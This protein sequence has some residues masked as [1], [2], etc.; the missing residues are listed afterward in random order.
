MSDKKDTVAAYCALTAALSWWGLMPLY[1]CFLKSVNPVEILAHRILWSFSFLLVVLK[2]ARGKAAINFPSFEIHKSFIPGLLLSVNWMAF[3][4][5]SIS[6]KALQASLGYFLAPLL[7]AALGTVF[8]HERLDKLKIL[9]LTL[10]LIGTTV[11]CAVQEDFPIYGLLLA[12]SFSSLALLRKVWP[13]HDAI[14]TTW[15]ETVV[16]LPVAILAFIFVGHSEQLS[17]LGKASLSID[18][19]LLLAGPLTVIPLALYAF[20][21]PKIELSDSAILQYLTPTVTFLLAILYFHE[22]VN[23]LK[24][25]GFVFIWLGLL[26][27][28]YN[29]LKASRIKQATQST[30]NREVLDNA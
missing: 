24:L 26:F 16:M 2:F 18:G 7:S 29:L 3:I 30:L 9:A 21:I 1:Y 10:G 23:Q 20:G 8:L 6:G 17:F 19:L 28:T 13:T 5:A 27:H 12:T 4:L 22:P 14:V 15:R 25:I 11:Q